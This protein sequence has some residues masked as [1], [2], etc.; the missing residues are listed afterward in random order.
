MNAFL[1]INPSMEE[2]AKQELAELIKAKGIAQDV[3]VEFSVKKNE[4]LLKLLSR[5]QSFRR[6]AVL[7]DK[8]GDI[9]ELDFSTLKF[10]WAEFFSSEVSL[11]V[12]VENVK[13]NDVRLDISRKV[14]GKLFKTLESKLKFSPKIELK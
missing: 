1:I 10:P 12:T 9:D 3:L 4:E 14:M 5:G 6:V 11:K 2:V 8:N 7:L 13:G